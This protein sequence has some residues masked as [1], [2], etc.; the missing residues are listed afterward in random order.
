MTADRTRQ[1]ADRP[2]LVVTGGSSG[3]GAE[4]C[5]LAARTGWRVWIGYATGED[6]ARRLSAE[7]AERGGDADVVP[8]PLD[9]PQALRDGVAV[10]AD[11]PAPVRAAALCGSP[12]PDVGT[13]TKLAPEQLRRQLDCAVT[14][15]HTLAAELWRRCLRAQGG[16][17]LLAVLSAAQGGTQGGPQAASHMAGYVAAK[18]GLEALLRAAAAELGRAGLRISVVRPGYVET[19]MLAAFE[20]RLLERARAASP[21]GRFLGPADVAGALMHGLLHPPEP[22]VVAELAADHGASS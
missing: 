22:G 4:L 15:N 3:I 1:N 2:A 5:R 18:G 7:I 21:G 13:F 6:R 20:P 19:P 8:L 17:H 10:I 9:D 12:A 11:H 16:G 14:G